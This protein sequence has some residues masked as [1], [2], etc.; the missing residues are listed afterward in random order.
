[1]ATRSLIVMLIVGLAG[2]YAHELGTRRAFQGAVPRLERLPSVFEGWHSED[3]PLTESVAKVLAADA[4]LQR[5]YHH[6]DGRDV[7]LFVAYFS[8]QTVNSQIHSPRHCIPGNGWEITSMSQVTVPRSRGPEPAERMLIERSGH[9]QE[10]L[11]WFRTRGGTVTGEYA[12]KWD[13]VRNSLAGRPTDA[14]FVR[15]SAPIE[16]GQTLREIVSR[17]DAP[18]NEILGEVGLE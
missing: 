3:T 8:R 14:V 17:L 16:D 11:Y 18:L 7:F 10:M 4:S 1:M 5:H 15:Y 9:T 2:A 13:L 12:L 6:R